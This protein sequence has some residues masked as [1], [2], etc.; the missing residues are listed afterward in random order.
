MARN[1]EKSK[2]TK[3]QI[4][5]T[6]SDAA[7]AEFELLATWLGAP[8]A[9][10]LRQKLEEFH[11]SQAFVDLLNRAKEAQQAGVEI[12]GLTQKLR[13]HIEK[14]SVAIS[15]LDELEKELVILLGRAPR[16]LG[17]I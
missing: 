12:A 5:I 17:D 14:D 8:K 9:S 6:L 7:D 3:N 2:S 10:L 15:L 4:N 1:S 11:Q 13:D 16:P